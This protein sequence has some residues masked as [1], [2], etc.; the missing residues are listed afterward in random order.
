MADGTR[1]KI[2]P[3]EN[4]PLLVEGLA[5]F[6]GPQGAIEGK[7]SMALC[8]CGASQNKPFCDG[9]HKG[10]EFSS[11]KLGDGPA[12]QR[13]SY[14]GK[15]VTIHDNRA[16]CAHAGICTERLPAVWR[17]RQEP[18]I[19]PDGGA[20]AEV[21]EVIKACPSGALAYTL[22]GTEERDNEGPSTITVVKSGPYV[23]RGGAQLEATARPTDVSEE[24]FTLC[25]CGASHNKP[26]CDGKHWDVPFDKD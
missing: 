4:G 17:M 5:E 11:A 25:R 12:D 14:A 20:L 16:V 23:V 8:R 19:D 6:S 1:P 9:Q 18:W 3:L 10:A 26:F 13:D 22:N 24:H 7:P 15:Q 21:I 2:T